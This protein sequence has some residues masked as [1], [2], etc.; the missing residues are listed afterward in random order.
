MKRA[1]TVDGGASLEEGV[2]IGRNEA[3]MSEG[4]EKTENEEVELEVFETVVVLR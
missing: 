1:E 2:G 4:D 3:L